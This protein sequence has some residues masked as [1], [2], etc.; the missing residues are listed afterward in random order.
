MVFRNVVI[1]KIWKEPKDSRVFGAFFDA[2]KLSRTINKNLF[3]ALKHL[4]FPDEMETS[5]PLVGTGM[6]SY[7]K[8]CEHWEHL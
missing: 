5:T 2:G 1:V 3:P 7:L 6:Q 8:A 4:T